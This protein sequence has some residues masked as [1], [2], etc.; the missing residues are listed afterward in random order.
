MSRYLEQLVDSESNLIIFRGNE[1]VFSSS[2]RGIAPLIEAIDTVGRESLAGVTTADRVVGKA[3]AL[4]VHHRDAAVHVPQ[5]HVGVAR[6][7]PRRARCQQ[8]SVGGFAQLHRTDRTQ[9]LCQK[10]REQ[11]RAS[12]ARSSPHVRKRERPQPYLDRLQLPGV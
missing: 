10:R 6:R 12:R 4:L 1:Q 5:H 8:G 2:G 11:W 9:T 3:A 7:E